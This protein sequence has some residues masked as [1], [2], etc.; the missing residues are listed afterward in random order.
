MTIWAPGM[1]SIHMTPFTCPF[2]HNF[3]ITR[4]DLACSLMVQIPLFDFHLIPRSRSFPEP[5]RGPSLQH[6]TYLDQ[7]ADSMELVSKGVV[8]FL[9]NDPRAGQNGRREVDFCAYLLVWIKA[10]DIA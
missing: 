10:L 4:R 2:N 1:P 7:E 6:G 9:D 3:L 8:Q 5:V